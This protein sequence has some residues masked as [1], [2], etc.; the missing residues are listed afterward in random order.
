[1]AHIVNASAFF[2]PVGS[3]VLGIPAGIAVAFIPGIINGLL[4]SKLRIPPFIGTLGMYGFQVS[5]RILVLR[6]GEKVGERL[7]SQTNHDEIVR[8]MVGG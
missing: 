5:D 1:M 8:L 2:G 6:R 3:L 4:I 7:I